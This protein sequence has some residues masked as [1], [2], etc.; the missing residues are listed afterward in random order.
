V[1]PIEGA[2]VTEEIRSLKDYPRCRLA[3]LSTRIEYAFVRGSRTFPARWEPLP[4]T[5]GRLPAVSL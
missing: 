2:K 5:K 3:W 1:C 4:R